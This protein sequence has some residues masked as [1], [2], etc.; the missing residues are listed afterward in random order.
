[1][2]FKMSR[3]QFFST[4]L[5]LL[6]G[7][8]HAVKNGA[9]PSEVMG[10]LVVNVSNIDALFR[11]FKTH[12]TQAFSGVKPAWQQ[13][14]TKVT[15]TTASED[16]GFLGS[17]PQL[18]EWIGDRHVKNLQ[19]FGYTLTNKKFE[20]SVG[21]SRDCI[22]DDRYG[23]FGSVFQD[24]GHAAATH[25]DSLVIPLLAAGKSSLCYDGQY[26]FDTDHPVAGGVK[27]NWG[28][29]TGKAWYLLDV[30]RPLKPLIF[31]VRRDYDL[32][33]MTR[34]DD[35]QVFMRDE[36]RY[37]VDARCAAGFGLWQMAY[38]SQQ[39]LNEASF[40]AACVAMATQTD[41][42][43]RPLGIR[44]NLLVV[45]P[46]MELAAL[47]LLKSKIVA[48]GADNPYYG[49]AEIMVSPWLP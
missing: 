6:I 14:A 40:E 17:F 46:S 35:E 12:F 19:A 15:S 8:V 29:G 16:Y 28:G 18:R 47:K 25:P 23:V 9:F 1:M 37:G 39:E 34:P 27:S 32:R 5:L 41:D 30:S 20:S 7:I 11:G 3:F 21:V 43:G 49:R 33:Q 38:G 22:E 2:F 4:L 31:Q 26:F 48:G 13:I 44:G 24:M 10:A 45:S 36:F 42:E